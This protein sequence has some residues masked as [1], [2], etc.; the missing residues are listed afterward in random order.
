[1]VPGREMGDRALNPGNTA[2]YQPIKSPSVSLLTTK[3]TGMLS[4]GISNTQWL[5][6]PLIKSSTCTMVGFSRARALSSS[7]RLIACTREEE[8]EWSPGVDG[9]SPGVPA[10]LVCMERP[11]CTSPYTFLTGSS[12]RSTNDACC[13]ID[14]SRA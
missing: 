12:V 1:M 5:I 4:N 3:L 7:L 14:C 9:A 10:V 13:T 8:E 6:K 2:Y 11:L